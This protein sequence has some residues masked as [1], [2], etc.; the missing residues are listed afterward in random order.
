M[1][2]RTVFLMSQGWTLLVRDEEDGLW[3]S[4]QGGTMRAA[5]A[6]ESAMLIAATGLAYLLRHL[7]EPG[8]TKAG[9]AAGMIQSCLAR[10]VLQEVSVMAQDAEV[11][12]GFFEAV[13]STMTDERKAMLRGALRELLADPGT[14]PSR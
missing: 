12:R 13:R 6:E 9:A 14:G 10:L 7:P 3:R 5:E 4:P 1:K 2:V 11:A 8:D